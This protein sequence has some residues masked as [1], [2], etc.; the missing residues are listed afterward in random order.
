MTQIP[1][2]PNLSP[3][4]L[5]SIKDSVIITTRDGIIYFINKATTILFGYSDQE[6]IGR[7]IDILIPLKKQYQY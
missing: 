1:A 3:V 4:I 5:D 2:I 7:N 6:L